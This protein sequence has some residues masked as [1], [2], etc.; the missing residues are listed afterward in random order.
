MFSCSV[1]TKCSTK[2]LAQIE[3]ENFI[4]TEYFHFFIINFSLKLCRGAMYE[5]S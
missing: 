3:G 1:H 2:V 5:V 4:I